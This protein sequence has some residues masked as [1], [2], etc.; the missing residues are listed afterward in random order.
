MSNANNFGQRRA[1]F[2]VVVAGSSGWMKSSFAAALPVEKPSTTASSV[3][4]TATAVSTG[5]TQH[6][7][8][9]SASTKSTASLTSLMVVITLALLS[10]FMLET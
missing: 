2:Q 9:V 6:D 1:E 7:G 10:N 5:D 4:P 3:L 8:H